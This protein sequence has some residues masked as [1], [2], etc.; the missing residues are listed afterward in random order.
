MTAFLDHNATAPL[1]PEA[2]EAMLA[3]LGLPCN[4]SSVHA[5]GRKA[6]SLVE[7]ARA[8]V[9][10]L[11]N[12]KPEE[13]IFVS[14]GTEA[15]ALAIR[16][17]G[18]EAV[19]CGA[20]EHDSVLANAGRRG[21]MSLIAHDKKEVIRAAGIGPILAAMTGKTLVS[22]M[23]A[24]NETGA[25]APVAGISSAAREAGALAH[26]DASQACGRI[27]VDFAALGI[28]YMT[29][30]SH[31]LGGPQGAGAL[32]VRDGA[33]LTADLA[34]GGQ[35]RGLRAGTENVAAIAGFGAACEVARAS[36]ADWSR[37]ERLR[38]EL[39]RAVKGALPHAVIHGEDLPRLP[40]T[41]MIG[42]RGIPGET[43]VIALDLAGVA[44]S[45]G[46]ACSSGKVRAS[47]VLAAM[48]VPK[49]EAA[50][51]IRV[52]M[53]WTSTQADVDAFLAAYIPFIAK[54]TPSRVPASLSA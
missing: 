49:G 24:N 15:N 41:S 52:S 44:V 38:D 7:R 51:A 32:I 37:V 31:K 39:E 4:A 45:S 48:D 16:G 11:V 46:A 36:L 21:T 50:C 9:A 6:R 30:S 29:I 43:Q 13:V 3:A 12:A 35:E 34:G 42:A 5:P 28:D 20:T 23:L 19:L 10:A 40:N 17:S 54:L 22:V 25:I 8:Q 2:R 14:G 33:P 53:G 27:P 1:R 18:A 26:T 47:H